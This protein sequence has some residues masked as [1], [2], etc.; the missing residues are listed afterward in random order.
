MAL[1]RRQIAPS[2]IKID[3]LSPGVTVNSFC[4][5]IGSLLATF[6]EEFELKLLLNTAL[7]SVA[8]RGMD[9]RGDSPGH[10]R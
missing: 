4:G 3:G 9:E 1:D 2:A 8:C 6:S 10:P 5:L 7:D